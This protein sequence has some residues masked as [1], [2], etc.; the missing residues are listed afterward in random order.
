MKRLMVVMAIVMVLTLALSAGAANAA[1]GGFPGPGFPGQ[2]FPGQ[3]QVYIVQRGDTLSGIAF[4]FGVSMY[5]LG[6]ANGVF[7]PNLIFVGQCLIIPARCC[8][9]PLQQWGTPTGYWGNQGGWGNQCWGGNQ[10]YG[11][12]NWGYGGGNWGY[13]GI[14][15]NWGGQGGCSTCNQP[16]P[17]QQNDLTLQQPYGQDPFARG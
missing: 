5:E 4:R 3:D 15:A 12:G 2:G 14:P 9:P 16:G 17:L 8:P 1:G 6:R 13:Q 11:G 10:C 7:N